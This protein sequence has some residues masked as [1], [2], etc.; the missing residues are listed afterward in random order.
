MIETEDLKLL[1]KLIPSTKISEAIGMTR[2]GLGKK[3]L[4][5]SPLN[6]TDSKKIT[7]YL[8]QYGLSYSR[9]NHS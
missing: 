3:L 7:E 9:K 5:N 4:S 1:V 6:T 8:S 2:Q